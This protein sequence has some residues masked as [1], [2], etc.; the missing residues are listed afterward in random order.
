[1]ALKDSRGGREYDKFIA[2]GSGDASIRVT[3][4]SAVTTSATAGT[5][6]T[7]SGFATGTGTATPTG[8][9]TQ[10]LAATS[11]EGKERIGIQIFNTGTASSPNTQDATYK[12]WG[13]LITTPGTVGGANWTQIGDDINIEEASN[14]Y[15][16]IATTPIKNIGVTGQSIDWNSAGGTQAA[17]TTNIYIMAD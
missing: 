8:G 12:V 5:G 10:L 2:D 17:T 3:S 14:A 16:A 11:V 15:K 1:M 6:S 13:S 7:T 4:T 9:Q